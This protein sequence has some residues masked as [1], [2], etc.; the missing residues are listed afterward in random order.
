MGTDH[1]AGSVPQ[2][3]FSLASLMAFII[4]MALFGSVTFCRF[5]C[6]W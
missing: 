3:Q 6:R 4:G 2:S 1:S 5:I